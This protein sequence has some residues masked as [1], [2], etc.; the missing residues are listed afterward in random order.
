MKLKYFLFTILLLSGALN[1]CKNYLDIPPMNVVQDKDLFSNATGM[2]VFLSRIYSQMPFEDFKYSPARQFFDDWLVTPGCNDGASLGRDAGTAMTS[3]GWA[4]NG[5][6]WGRAFNLLRDANRLLETLPNYKSNFSAAD[7]NHFIGEGYFARAMVFYALAKRYGGMPLITS[8]LKYP[9]VPADQLE[10]PR[11]TEEETWNQVLADFD[12]AIANLSVSSPKRGYANKYVAYSFKSEAMLFAGSVAKYN[13]IT[14]FGDK[15]GVRVIGFDPNTAAAA[16]KKYFTEAYKAAREV[17]KSGKYSLYK[18]K[19]S[20]N[21]KGAQ[22]QNMVDMFSD[23]SSSEN[24]Y[25]KE[26]KYPDLTHGYDAYNI[27]RQLMG[28]NG[29][30]AGNCPTL[31]F[32]EMFDGFAKN[33]DGTI[34]VFDNNGKYIL[35]DNVTDIFANAEPRLRAYVIFPGDVFKGEV[36]EIRRGIYT[37]DASKGISPLRVVNGG[38]P[39][40]TVSGPSNYNQVDAYKAIGAFAGKKSLFMSQNGTTHE[41]V[42]LPDGTKMNG[43]GKNGPF[44]G[45]NTAAMT[46]FT[47]RKWLNPNMPQSLVLEAR[48]EQHFVLMRYAEILLNAAEAA[49]ELMLAGVP[50]PAGEDFQQIAYNAIKD[51]RERAGADP[52]TGVASIAGQDGL[53]IIRKE[54]K[55]ELAFENKTLWDIRRWRTQHSDILN[56]Y[57]QADGAYYK[58]LYPFYS[59]TTGKYFFD[60]GLDE[61]R[62]RFRL[63]EPEY[64]F[65]IPGGE[66]SKSRVID[67][68]PGR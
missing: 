65:A 1:S 41:T 54:R 14:G 42:T 35:F 11:S 5:A 53:Q 48:S 23:I 37:G 12:L 66:V 56:G 3:E 62:R 33:A 55:K 8:V 30:S 49:S 28:G 59:S 63:T 34:K 60:A 27:P 21:D 32:V 29:Y 68:Q 61:S 24:I 45:D 13:K 52:L 22:Y 46:G 10:T 58:G 6:Y 67:Q 26:Y 18:K 31:D 51:I 47:I 40:Y 7:Y 44:T 38:A 17:M 50:A 16:S 57:T 15:T 39:D 4:R 2:T 20:A 64:Y 36:I 43:G 19:W 9:D 25:I